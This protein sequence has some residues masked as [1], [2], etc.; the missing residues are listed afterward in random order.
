M[1]IGISLLIGLLL[2]SLFIMMRLDR[3]IELL[4]FTP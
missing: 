2:M 4:E 3:I 1:K